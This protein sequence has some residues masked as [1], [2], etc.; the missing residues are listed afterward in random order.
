M[1]KGNVHTFCIANF[2]L[3]FYINQKN[4]RNGYIIFCYCTWGWDTESF[5]FSLYFSVSSHFSTMNII[6]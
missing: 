2:V 6:K 3:K 5:S 4:I 1:K